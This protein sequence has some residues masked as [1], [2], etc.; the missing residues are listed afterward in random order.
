VEITEQQVEEGFLSALGA[1][2]ARLLKARD[3]TTLALHY[4]YARALG[5]PAALALAADLDFSLEQLGVVAIPEPA[6]TKVTVKYFRPAFCNL[7]ALVECRVQIDADSSVLLELV[8]VGTTE[9]REVCVE[10]ISSE[11]GY[12]A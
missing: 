2:A 8:V 11:R 7:S 5:R 12:A 1:D 10:D 6:R 4:P 3:F 9:R